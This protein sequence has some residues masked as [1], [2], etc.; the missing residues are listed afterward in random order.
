MALPKKLT[1]ELQEE[2]LLDFYE[3]PDEDFVASIINDD[4]F[5]SLNVSEDQQTEYINAM[6]DRRNAQLLSDN[7]VPLRQKLD[8]VV[9]PSGY[10]IPKTEFLRQHSASAE[11]ILDAASGLRE[12]DLKALE[13]APE[14]EF[15]ALG[16]L[17]R[18]NED[19][20]RSYNKLLIGKL[21]DKSVHIKMLINQDTASNLKSFLGLFNKT[22]F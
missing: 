4:R 17:I 13:A 20:S 3:L 5:T 15:S 6:K 9:D 8:E 7:M 1:D 10:A 18:T 12:V 11:D 14:G 22:Y 21:N 2:I 19:V 16:R